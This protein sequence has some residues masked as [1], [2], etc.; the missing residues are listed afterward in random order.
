MSSL[1]VNAAPTKKFSTTRIGYME[2]EY[3]K[4][5]SNRKKEIL[6]EL[7]DGGFA[8][9]AKQFVKRYGALEEPV[10]IEV[11]VVQEQSEQEHEQQKKKIEQERIA[12]AKKYAQEIEHYKQSLQHIEN[13]IKSLPVTAKSIDAFDQVGQQIDNLAA[14]KAQLQTDIGDISSLRV[15]LETSKQKFIDKQKKEYTALAASIN[16]LTS[17][18]AIVKTVEQAN[19][20]LELLQ[21][22]RLKIVTHAIEQQSRKE[23]S[24]KL[25]A[26]EQELHK[27]KNILLA[28]QTEA[29]KQALKEQ[30]E[31]EQQ[32]LLKKQEDERAAQEKQK[33]IE[34]DELQK[35]IDTLLDQVRQAIQVAQ[36][37]MTQEAIIE[38]RKII[39]EL[40][41]SVNQ[42]KILSQKNRDQ[43]AESLRVALEQLRIKED[44][45]AKPALAQGKAQII[46]QTIAVPSFA[47]GDQSYQ[48]VEITTDAQG[49]VIQVKYG[50]K[51]I[52]SL[53]THEQ[54][55][56]LQ[57]IGAEIAVSNL[58]KQFSFIK[59]AGINV[60]VP[61]AGVINQLNVFSNGTEQSL[62][63][64]QESK[65]YKFFYA[66]F[67]PALAEK[68]RRLQAQE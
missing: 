22:E 15:S 1:I 52:E 27:K 26:L 53:G 25:H 38:Q 36:N 2:V 11:P 40:L 46:Q 30:Q 12:Q 41:E 24:D 35:K 18:V 29:E 19:Q 58:V 54:R 39:M 49:N 64:K 48:D 17:E 34:Q 3:R 63:N 8:H 57:W 42:S 67:K 60:E 47:G 14:R 16:A 61:I 51:V 68:L 6:Q 13:D 5:S 37:A 32:A 9:I 59:S 21:K 7:T 56:D 20:L 4:A 55:K 23:L 43:S 65:E 28:K 44:S 10:A 45:I 33:Q 66:Y 50:K 31:K 62:Q